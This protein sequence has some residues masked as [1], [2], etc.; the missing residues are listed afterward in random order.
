MRAAALLLLLASGCAEK[1]DP[2]DEPDA[3][4]GTPLA[5]FRYTA[6]DGRECVRWRCCLDGAL[7]PNTECSATS[8]PQCDRCESPYYVE[9]CN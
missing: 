2:A 8:E 6:V 1:V 3:R 4:T 9:P 7:I 5:C